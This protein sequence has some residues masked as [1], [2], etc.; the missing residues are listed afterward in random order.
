MMKKSTILTQLL[1]VIAIIVVA[2]LISR[3]LYFRIDFTED[4]RYTLSKATRDILQDLDEVITVKAYFTEN[5]PA[6]L[7]FVQSDLRDQL[8]EY[9]DLAGGNLIFEFINPSESDELK[10]E[11]IQSG[12]A[13]LSINV[14]ENDQQQ[15]IQA[16]LGVVLKSGENTEAIPVVQPNGGMEY[17]LTMAI[18]KLAIQDK[19]KIGMIS[20]YGSP[21]LSSFPQLVE[22]LS[23]LYDV[24]EFSIADTF[25]IPTFYRGLIWVAPTDTIAPIEFSKLDQYLNQG[26][27]LFLSYSSVAGNLQQGS[28]QPA[29]DI[30]IKNWVAGKGLSY[31]NEFVIDQNCL[32]VTVQQRQGFLTINSQVS[33]PLLPRVSN[34]DDHPI[35]EGLEQVLLPFVNAFTIN[36][37][38][39]TTIRIN[40]LA[41]T[42]SKSGTMPAPGIL[43]INRK[44]TEADFPLQEQILASSIEGLGPGNGAMVVIGNGDFIINGEG[45]QAQ[46]VNPDNLNFASNAIDWLADDTGLIGLRTKAI[47]ARTLDKIDDGTKNLLKYGNVFAPILLILIYAGI[48]K[49]IRI[50]RKQRW[51]QGNFA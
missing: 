11:A 9:E 49:Q 41:F 25:S 4:Q 43:D 36:N 16:F 45:Q 48:R 13:P 14:V 24:E 34:F 29:P 20:G 33:V 50:R 40:P 39:D 22:Q 46:R 30:G 18:K 26:G 47:T 8:V 10:Q 2:N 19:P 7:A 23:V 6:Q 21:S 44:W 1:I 42:S 37:N 3:N 32:P 5:L 35:T 38:A 15:Q 28:L 17:D 31:N 27:K 51:A 12:V